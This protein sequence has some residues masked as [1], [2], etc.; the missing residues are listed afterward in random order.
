M[1]RYIRLSGPDDENSYLYH[2]FVTLGIFG[3][4]SLVAYGFSLRMISAEATIM[5]YLLCVFLVV[6]RTGRF[7]LGVL[8]SIGSTMVYYYFFATP[9]FSYNMTEPPRYLVTMT[10]MIVVALV[11]SILTSRVRKEAQIALERGELNEQLLHLN[12]DLADAKSAE[13]I[14]GVALTAINEGLNC[15]VGYVAFDRNGTPRGNYVYQ[16]AGPKA[17]L[18]QYPFHSTEGILKWMM[19]GQKSFI[20]GDEFY[21]WP[22]RG[23]AGLVGAIRIRIGDQERM[24]QAE[25][26]LLHSIIDSTCL[27]LDRYRTAELRIQAREEASEERFRSTLLRS[28]SHDIRT[29]LTS[30][31]GNAEML[32][33][34]LDS[35]DL[36]YRMAKNIYDDAQNLSGMVENVLGITRLESGVHIKKEVEAAEE[37][38]GAAVKLTE[39]HHPEYDIKVILPDEI[40][41]VPMD[42]SLIQ[43]A[44]TNLL[45]NAIHHTRKTDGVQ[46]ILEKNGNNAVFRVRDQGKGINPEHLP[47][48]FEPFYQSNRGDTVV[49]RGFGLGL[50]IC[51]SIVRA[52]GGTIK[53]QN[54]K[55]TAGAEIVFTLPM[56]PMEEENGR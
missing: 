56:E 49:Y 10:V 19:E 4:T 36:N 43:Q 46:V 13:A 55:D 20:R 31:C 26:Q 37:V 45:E 51:D 15:G 16:T 17:A 48:L 14:M 21:E 29:P 38:I 27:A 25:I 3:A 2:V 35:E 47:H 28:I 54:R 41:F 33:H 53:A 32:M 11:T 22:L 34:A 23:H 18:T 5:L 30:I 39:V 40:L 44:V 6:W 24:E 12:N 52:H 1:D 50:S 9:K 7:E 8:A 42:A